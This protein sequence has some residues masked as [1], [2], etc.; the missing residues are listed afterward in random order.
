VNINQD[1]EKTRT[2]SGTKLVGE[3]ATGEVEIRN[4][5]ADALELDKGTALVASNSLEFVLDSSAS[6]PAQESPGTPGV[7]KVR[8]AAS[9]I[10]SEYNLP[11]DERFKVSNYPK[12]EVDA[13]ATS[14]FTGGASREIRAVSKEDQEE[15]LS[16][17]TEELKQ[18]G[19][20]QLNSQIGEDEFFVEGATAGVVD[21]QSF[22]AK[23]GDE[24]E[25]L[26]LTLSVD[27][28]GVVVSRADLFQLAREELREKP[29]EG[30][31]LR[32]SQV[33][34]EFSLKEAKDDSFELAGVVVANLLPE[35]NPDD[36]AREITGKY[37]SVAQEYLTKIP[38][39][40]RAQISIS[41]RFPGKLGSLPRVTKNITVEVAANK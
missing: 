7:G 23:V 32:E 6:I 41:P 18:K 10:G 26:K 30:Y 35:V 15:L 24:A 14:D 33:E 39:F 36:I 5:R 19:A 29:P 11:K 40:T 9:D 22:S 12:A 3:K 25:E 4:G 2:A 28:A 34:Y 21:S 13:I 17:L 20:G 31:V 1:G 38:G 16:E 8:L 27:V 37:P